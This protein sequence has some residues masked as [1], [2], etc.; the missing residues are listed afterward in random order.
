VVRALL[1]LRHDPQLR[2]QMG[3]AARKRAVEKFGREPFD[4]RLNQLYA[5]LGVHCGERDR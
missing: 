3:R 1:K 2:A 5:R 4:R